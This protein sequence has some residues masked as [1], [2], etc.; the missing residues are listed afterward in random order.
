MNINHRGKVKTGQI[1][2]RR[3][4]KTCLMYKYHR[5]IGEMGQIRHGRLKK[6][7]VPLGHFLSSWAK[8]GSK[9]ALKGEFRFSPL[10]V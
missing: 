6:T 2:L 3:P 4:K 1:R 9:D 7:L 5:G 8:K 10:A